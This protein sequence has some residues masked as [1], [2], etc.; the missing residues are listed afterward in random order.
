MR[1][2]SFVIWWFWWNIKW[3]IYKRSPNFVHKCSTKWKMRLPSVTLFFVLANGEVEHTL[4][5]PLPGAYQA[6]VCLPW[7]LGYC[8]RRPLTV[9]GTPT[10]RNHLKQ[11]GGHRGCYYSEAI[12]SRSVDFGVFCGIR[13]KRVSQEMLMELVHNMHSVIIILYLLSSP[14]GAKIN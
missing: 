14:P 6:L 3:R 9:C 5:C 4:Y 1:L 13:L 7:W 8:C 10:T 2:K 11:N 12:M